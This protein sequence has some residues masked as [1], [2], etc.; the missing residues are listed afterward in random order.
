M[1]DYSHLFDSFPSG[2]PE[3]ALYR[4][5]KR[6]FNRGQ[7]SAEICI[8]IE[9]RT[10]GVPMAKQLRPDL[11][12]ELPHE[13]KLKASIKKWVAVTDHPTGFDTALITAFMERYQK[14]DP[15]F[16]KELKEVAHVQ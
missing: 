3:N 8:H 9:K 5:C 7:Y 1:K 16:Y 4:K 10:D 6:E 11:F 12:S 14:R 2:T 13:T 15:Q